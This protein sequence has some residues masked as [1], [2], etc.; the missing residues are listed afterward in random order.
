MTSSLTTLQS[1]GY[2][3]SMAQHLVEQNLATFEPG[4]VV[5]EHKERYVVRTAAGDVEAEI[6]GNLRF[7]SKVGKITPP[8]VIGWC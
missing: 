1:L 7:T 6:T 4:R 3:P 2:T 8:W 5:A